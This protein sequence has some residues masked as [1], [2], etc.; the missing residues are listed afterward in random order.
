MGRAY[1]LDLR[2]RVAGFVAAGGTRRAA[3]RHFAISV[4][5][6]VRIAAT[7]AAG[8]TLEPRKQ[9][10]P[11]GRGKLAP[12]AGFLLEIVASVPDI[13]LEEL[14]S[15]LEAEHGV[16]A[17]PSSISRLLTRHELTY[18]KSRCTPPSTPARTCAPSAATG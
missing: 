8:G 6:A 12:Y 7:Q 14:A 2:E 18:K 17:H 16:R 10:R 13:A 3:A 1:S 11:P 4:S 5:T 9:G 15:A